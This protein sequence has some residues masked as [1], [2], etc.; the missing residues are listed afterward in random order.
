MN[1]LEDFSSAAASLHSLDAAAAGTDA[2]G[3]AVVAESVRAASPLPLPFESSD[4]DLRLRPEDEMFAGEQDLS[5]PNTAQ[6]MNDAAE[7]ARASRSLSPPPKKKLLGAKE[8]RGTVVVSGLMQDKPGSKPRF[9]DERVIFQLHEQMVT[10]QGREQVRDSIHGQPTYGTRLHRQHRLR[11]TVTNALTD[12]PNAPLPGINTAAL[13]K[14]RHPNEE[15]AGHEETAI[16]PRHT[17]ERRR[18]EPVPGTHVR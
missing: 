13:E 15:R 10:V 3:A 18:R 4:P 8:I 12:K 1:V 6:E 17:K 14:H 11:T 9:D 16:E 2:A 7:A 5:R